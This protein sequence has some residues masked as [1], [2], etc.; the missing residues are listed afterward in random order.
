MGTKMKMDKLCRSCMCVAGE[1]RQ[2]FTSAGGEDEDDATS[3][4]VVQ[5]HTHL[6]QMIMACSD[7][8]IESGDGLPAALCLQCEMKVIIAFDFKQLCEKSDATLRASI[9]GTTDDIASSSSW[10]DL[11]NVMDTCLHCDKR[12]KSNQKLEEHMKTHQT[13]CEHCNINF[14]SV[15]KLMEHKKDHEVSILVVKNEVEDGMDNEADNYIDETMEPSPENFATSFECEQCEK[16][17]NSKIGLK[18]HMR[19]HGGQGSGNSCSICSKTFS[20]ASMMKKHMETTHEVYEEKNGKKIMECEFCDRKFKYKKSFD[21]HMS[22]E[23]GIA[24]DD[25]EDSD[26]PLSEFVKNS[27]SMNEEDVL[28]PKIEI[29]KEEVVDDMKETIKKRAKCHEC[30]V[31]NTKFSRT[32][33]LTRH[34]TLHR[35][36]LIFKCDKCDKSFATQDFL[37]K[38]NE[39]DHINKPYTCTVCK[40][41]FSRG[42]HL[43]RHLKQHMPT[44]TE[45]L[46]C[47]VCMKEFKRS[48][49]LARHIKI[50]LQQDKRHVCTECGKTF[51]RLDNLKTHQ[52]THTGQKYN[53]KLHLCIYCGKEFNNS[54]N[55]IVHMRRHTGERPYKCKQCGK[56]FPRSHDLKCHERTHS[57][58]KPYLCTLC[59]KSFNKSNK[60]L[61][62][63]RVHTGERPYVCNLCGR[64]FTQSNDLALHMRRHTGSRP[65]ACGVCPARFIQS[66][67][68]KTHR[69]TTGHW[70]EIQP[71]L[72]GGHRVEPVVAT[73][74]LT[75]VK[76]KMSAKYKDDLE[77]ATHQE[78]GHSSNQEQL[79]DEVQS[80]S[81]VPQF[82]V[83]DLQQFSPEKP[84]DHPEQSTFHAYTATPTSST[85]TVTTSEQFHYQSF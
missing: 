35:A 1:I 32:N 30:H 15:E 54:S 75:P 51:N 18:I 3:K 49:H 79:V 66:G 8:K 41:T 70:M 85:F 13:L 4:E 69:K 78:E 65:Y 21:H 43:I 17:F 60:L 64:A 50:H 63:T 77:D 37:D 6:A 73:T 5:Q 7:I 40:K 67:Q 57:G 62:H 81:V 52:R 55:M 46:Q 38:H 36:V 28:T 76:F 68:L 22:S 34:M 26:T 84:K 12:F 16:V 74:D 44:I 47:S 29:Q 9:S 23:H 42:E 20:K 10:Q 71:D 39:E 80:R 14:D 31:C 72:K 56:G 24:E 45:M 58:E 2:L 19:K 53:A 25:D 11:I 48:D 83:V 61:R 33:H 27:S 82:T 59:G